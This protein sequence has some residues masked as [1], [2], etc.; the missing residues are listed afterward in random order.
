MTQTPNTPVLD[1]PE[2]IVDAL[3]VLIG[4]DDRRPDDVI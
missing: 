4:P 2:A 1:S 3:E